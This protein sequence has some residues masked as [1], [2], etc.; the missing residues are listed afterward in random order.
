MTCHSDKESKCVIT[1]NGDLR[2]NNEE[3]IDVFEC[4][5]LN[6]DA[7][8]GSSGKEMLPEKID[9]SNILISLDQDVES[10]IDTFQ[11]GCTEYHSL[12]SGAFLSC[13]SFAQISWHSREKFPVRRMHVFARALS[14]SPRKDPTHE[15]A[16]IGDESIPV[17]RVGFVQLNVTD[18][19]IEQSSPVMHIDDENLMIGTMRY[20]SLR[21]VP[22]RIEMK[23]KHREVE[24]PPCKDAVK[25]RLIGHRG[26]GSLEFKKDSDENPLEN[27]LLSFETAGQR[28]IPMVELDVQLARDGLPVIY[29]DLEI[30]AYFR[31]VPIRFPTCFLK[32]TDFALY[33]K[34]KKSDPTLSQR[35]LGHLQQFWNFI[36]L[37]R[38]KQQI[39]ASMAQLS[40]APL[41]A[42]A[43]LMTSKS[44]AFNVEVKFPFFGTECDVLGHPVYADINA[45]VDTILEETFEHAMDREIVFSCFSPEVCLLLKAK[46]S[47][48]PVLFL[49]M[50]ACPNDEKR[51][52]YSSAL[53]AQ[54]SSL[55]GIVCES[56]WIEKCP[57]CVSYLHSK[58]E[59]LWTYGDRN[60]N[61]EFIQHQIDLGVDRVVTDRV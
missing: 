23:Q 22:C 32:T 40:R 38:V 31:K 6:R 4:V 20:R 54:L 16:K 24:K 44:V 48:F 50:E 11:P 5:S 13:D 49:I 28:G 12:S 34:P 52:I 47:R 33:A 21:C 46:Q 7:L 30:T 43:L 26:C 19:V 3:P 8:F 2:S 35:I 15:V 18:E 25:S 36:S 37:K 29:H 17:I 56:T 55:D 1:L 39:R 27:T 58:G 61:A 10:T 42:Q 57:E 14:E 45:Y 41:Y 59:L 9:A 60:N 53:F 51:T